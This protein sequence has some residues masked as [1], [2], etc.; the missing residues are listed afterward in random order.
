MNR[1]QGRFAAES[2]HR[3]HNRMIPRASTG[4]STLAWA[5]PIDPGDNPAKLGSST[6]PPIVTVTSNSAFASGDTGA[7]IRSHC[8]IAAFPAAKGS[9]ATLFPASVSITAHPR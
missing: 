5:S 3:H 7:T 9:V 6:I 8:R 4:T 1:N 2:A